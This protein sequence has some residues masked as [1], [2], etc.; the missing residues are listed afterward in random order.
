VPLCRCAWTIAKSIR[1]RLD[2]DGDLHI[3]VRGLVFKDSPLVQPPSLIG[4]NDEAE[5]ADW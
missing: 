3:R 2:T 5:F 1:G 4:T